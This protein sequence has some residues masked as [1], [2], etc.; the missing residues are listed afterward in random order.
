MRRAV[1]LVSCDLM[2]L[3][4]QILSF[5]RVGIIILLRLPAGADGGWVELLPLKSFLKQIFML[6]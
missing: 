2:A 3:T 6:T 5:C 1:P 4:R